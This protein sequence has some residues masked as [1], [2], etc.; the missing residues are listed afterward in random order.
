MSVDTILTLPANVHV[1]DVLEVLLRLYG[2]QARPIQLRAP[3]LFEAWGVQGKLSCASRA[4]IHIPTRGV[5]E[6]QSRRG[7]D[8]FAWNFEGEGGNRTLKRLG[9]DEDFPWPVDLFKALADFFGGY[10]DFRDDDDIEKDYEVP[11]KTKLENR[12]DEDPHHALFMA[13]IE[14]VQ[15]IV[16]R[17]RPG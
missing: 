12:P 17:R 2:D 10:I 16:L 13:R 8:L 4:D 5:F 14:A 1:R 3:Y 6:S 7:F 9:F 11:F 15:P